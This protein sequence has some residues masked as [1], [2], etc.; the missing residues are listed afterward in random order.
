MGTT[1]VHKVLFVNIT[2]RDNDLLT[3]WPFCG[4]VDMWLEFG[5]IIFLD[6][7]LNIVDFS[8]LKRRESLFNSQ[9]FLSVANILG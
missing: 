1:F 4:H 5:I 2:H 8:C 7:L 6:D 3:Q 9:H